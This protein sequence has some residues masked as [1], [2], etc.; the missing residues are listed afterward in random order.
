ML[1]GLVVG[2]LVCEYGVVG[3]GGEV[4]GEPLVLG[5][6]FEG[7]GVDETSAL[8][9]LGL[10][11]DW[12]GVRVDDGCDARV[13]GLGVDRVDGVAPTDRVVGD[14][15]LPPTEG[16]EFV[17]GASTVDEIGAV[18]MTEGAGVATDGVAIA[19]DPGEGV[20]LADPGLPETGEPP[21]NVGLLVVGAG[22]EVVVL[23]GC[24]DCVI[25]VDEGVAAGASE[26]GGTA[27]SQPI[28]RNTHPHVVPVTIVHSASS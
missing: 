15:V 10:V 27:S 9:A 6:G 24:I 17:D 16:L 12:F 14:G 23:L 2:P 7:H 25:V 4:A 22:V 28:D 21:E 1:A 13:V 26:L 19:V 18:E 11:E 8:V 5:R 20:R 3:Y